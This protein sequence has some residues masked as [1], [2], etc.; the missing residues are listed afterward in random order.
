MRRE[1]LGM[2]R[3]KGR[4]RRGTVSETQIERERESRFNQSVCTRILSQNS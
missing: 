3:E 2:N 1:E 4:K